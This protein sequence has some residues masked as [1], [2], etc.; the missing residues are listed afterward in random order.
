MQI[1][2]YH[3][4]ELTFGSSHS[5][6]RPQAA[7]HPTL[8]TAD[9]SQLEQFAARL[10][11]KAVA[12][13]HKKSE[14]YQLTRSLRSA[15]LSHSS[16]RSYVTCRSGFQFTFAREPLLLLPPTMLIAARSCVRTGKILRPI[17]EQKKMALS[18][19]LRLLDGF[20]GVFCGAFVQ[21]Y[22]FSRCTCGQIVRLGLLDE[23]L[24]LL[25]LRQ[26][27][28]WLSR[29][30]NL[31]GIRRFFVTVISK[32]SNTVYTAVLTTATG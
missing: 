22:H 24:Q 21:S 14:S 8:H 28:C 5:R 1:A 29:M 20:Y 26:F 17:Q 19:G 3:L 25:R 16:S 13:E 4:F 31:Q 23:L 15:V 10:S 32:F 27:L 30:V 6:A 11:H 12:K 7:R 2:L 9:I 18:F